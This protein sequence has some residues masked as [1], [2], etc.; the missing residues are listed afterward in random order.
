VIAVAPLALSDLVRSPWRTL[1]RV[2]TLAAAVGLLGAMLLFVG[3]SLGTMTRTAARSV[4]LDWQGPVGSYKAARRVA[5]GVAGQPG[6]AEAVPAATAPFAGLEHASP[7]AGTIRSGAGSILAVPTG[8][9]AHLKTFRFLRG[10]MRAGEIV[11]DQ[12][13]AATLQAQPGDTVLMTPRTGAQPT[14]FLVSG[15]ALITAPD[16]LFQRS[17]LCSA[18]RPPSPQPTSRSSPSPPSPSRS[19]PALQSISSASGASAVPGRQTGTQWQVQAQVD[20]AELTGSPAHA[21]V[22]ATGIRNSAERALPGQVV[23]VDNLV[24]TLNTATADGLY[25]ETLYIMLAVPGALAALG[26]AYLAAL[27]TVERDRQSLALLRARGARRRGLITLAT[28]ESVLL[29]IVAGALGTGLAL[30]AVQ[31]AAAGSGVGD[32]LACS[33]P[34]ASASPSPPRARRPP[35]SAPGSP[36]SAAAS[37]RAVAA[38]VGGECRSGSGSTSTLSASP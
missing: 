19:R 21:L 3:H 28:L 5:A 14:R 10:S 37:V 16:Q 25:A 31:L 24:D 15:I 9:L 1:V 7:T 35:G 22:L 6:V 17:I 11:L 38:C 33:P 23:F 32:Q 36:P 20:Q 13:L 8:Y 30:G 27:G 4:P 29:G 26:L 18:R 34:S 12:Q 2:L